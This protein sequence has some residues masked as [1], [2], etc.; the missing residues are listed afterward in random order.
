MIELP[1]AVVNSLLEQAAQEPMYLDIDLAPQTVAHAT[2][3]S[4]HFDYEPFQ[5]HC[6]LNGLD[7]L[8]Y[9]CSHNVEIEQFF[10]E[11]L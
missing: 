6:L 3:G 11:H 8:D 10:R 2:L 5:K 9:L 4:W 1:E 7:Q